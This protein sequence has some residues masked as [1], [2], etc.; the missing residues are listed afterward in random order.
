MASVEIVGAANVLVTTRIVASTVIK[1]N[2]C[3]G[4]CSPEAEEAIGGITS[5][6]GLGVRCAPE[7]PYPIV[8]RPPGVG[9][10]W[11]G[12]REGRE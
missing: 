6:V 7:P 4:S 8:R 2:V 10:T 12:G 11:V 1:A 5:I 9:H 3:G